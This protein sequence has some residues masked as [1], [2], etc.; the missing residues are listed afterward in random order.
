MSIFYW[1][2]LNKQTS[3]KQKFSK[4]SPPVKIVQSNHNCVFLG[5]EPSIWLSCRRRVKP[6][7]K[8]EDI[9]WMWS[10][11]C[12][13]SASFICPPLPQYFSVRALTDE[14]Q[15]S[16]MLSVSLVHEPSLC[17]MSLPCLFFL[18]TFIKL[19]SNATP[20]TSIFESSFWLENP[21][22]VLSLPWVWV[23]MQL[24]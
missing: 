4:L 5:C 9:Q 10:S 18:R 17:I 6:A 13:F 11:W 23:L 2:A 22:Y 16:E 3:S 24:F 8:N 20:V 15:V 14:A 7:W 19:V 1:T 21:R 12:F